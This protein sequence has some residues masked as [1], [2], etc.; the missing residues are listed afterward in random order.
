MGQAAV[1]HTV[2]HQ[3]REPFSCF[4]MTRKDQPP[5]SA[6]KDEAK[7]LWQMTHVCRLTPDE[8]EQCELVHLH[9]GEPSI[10]KRGQRRPCRAFRCI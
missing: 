2:R 10:A 9:I 3:L 1:I 4:H 7:R 5:P 6:I 8:K